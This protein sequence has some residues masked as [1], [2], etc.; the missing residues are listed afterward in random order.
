MGDPGS[1]ET[2]LTLE[3]RYAITSS[4]TFS[5][6]WFAKEGTYEAVL[7]KCTSS[8]V[9]SGT[10]TFARGELTLS[11]TE[12]PV[13]KLRINPGSATDGLTTNR[14]APR[15]APTEAAS[16]TSD[17]K[18]GDS[19]TAASLRPRVEGEPGTEAVSLLNGCPSSLLN[20]LGTFS[21]GDEGE[22][23]R[24]GDLPAT[25]IANG[26]IYCSYHVLRSCIFSSG[27]VTVDSDDFSAW[28][29]SEERACEGAFLKGK[30]RFPPLN[31][32]ACNYFGSHKN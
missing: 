8:C 11:P 2:G 6:L 24:V 27:T 12:G 26:G 32:A 19:A 7:A 28:A 10:F 29:A 21:A 14:L 4:T 31:N 20:V 25:K 9:R 18:T 15:T 1:E 22:G 5:T 13:S 16:A 30:E 17:C 23:K 3:G